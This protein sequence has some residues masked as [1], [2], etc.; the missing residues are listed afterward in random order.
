[1]PSISEQSSGRNSANFA[2]KV[3]ISVFTS[4]VCDLSCAAICDLQ[5][6][7]FLIL[8]VDFFLG[9]KASISFD[10][11]TVV[12]SDRYLTLNVHHVDKVFGESKV[13]PLGFIRVQQRATADNLKH[14]ISDRLQS[15]GL[16]ECDLVAA[17][18]DAGSNVV[19]AV[20]LMGLRKQKCF[21]HG[22][23]L[24][25]RK[26]TYGRKATAFDVVMISAFVDSERDAQQDAD[27]DEPWEGVLNDQTG[28]DTNDEG[29][30]DEEHDADANEENEADAGEAHGE[31]D[32]VVF[33]EVVQRLRDV[34]RE[35]K[36]K[37]VM[38]DE[39]RKVTGKEEFNNKSLKVI[40]DCR[41]R[42]Y[43]TLLMI[44]RALRILPAMNNVLSR[45]SVPISA[46]DAIALEEIA[47]V[48]SP[49]KHAILLLCKKEAS[50]R[51]ADKIFL[52]ILQDLEKMGSELADMLLGR[53]KRE[54]QK[55][56][57]ILSTLLAVLDDPKYDFK[58]EREIGVR[59]PSETELVNVLHEIVDSG[60]ESPLIDSSEDEEPEVPFFPSRGV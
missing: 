39:L 45:H 57:T 44:E 58:L 32:L 33:G 51:V 46:Q 31:E 56:R 40:L 6:C 9:Y 2:L 1:M 54:L 49:F 20:R 41:T 28:E 21:T 52:L 3:R 34:C 37:P 35:F 16:S 42:W 53:L 17:A 48:L 27:A 10:E 47:A 19:K 11:A 14:L 15:V 5:C 13:A 23:D 43:S 4:L 38:M 26:V 60:T 7:E 25:V 59:V 36:K 12:G 55:R 8:I 29:H 30:M 50:L 24:V 18:T 22:L